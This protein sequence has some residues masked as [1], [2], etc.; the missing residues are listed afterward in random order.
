MQCAV[1]LKDCKD[2]F[3]KNYNPSKV[4]MIVLLRVWKLDKSN[5]T[6]KLYLNN[7]Y[8]HTMSVRVSGLIKERVDLSFVMTKVLSSDLLEISESLLLFHSVIVLK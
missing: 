7:L 4:W 1:V 6:L 2:H 8:V 3:S 5:L